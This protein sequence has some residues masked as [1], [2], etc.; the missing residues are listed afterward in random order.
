VRRLRQLPNQCV[1]P[2]TGANNQNLHESFAADYRG[3]MKL[4]S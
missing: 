3:G 2:S 1:F 4:E